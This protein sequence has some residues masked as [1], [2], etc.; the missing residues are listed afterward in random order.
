VAYREF[1]PRPE[2]SD[3]VACTWERR[4]PV[5]DGPG[6]TRVLPDGCIDLI[7][8]DGGLL[9][10]GPDRQAFMSPLRPG[11]TI[12]G[13]RLRPGAAGGVL[14]LPASE[15]RDTR[16]ELDAVWEKAGDELAERVDAADA[17]H[18][19]RRALEDALLE[20]L[21]TARQPDTLVLAAARLLGRPGSRVG[22]LRDALG[23]SERQLLRRFQAAVGYGPKTLDRVL[24]FQRFVS[25][26][27]HEDL[28]RAAADLGYADQA[29]MTRECVQLSG[30]TPARLASTL[31]PAPD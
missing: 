26:A 9:V 21:S 1:Q 30:L 8:R 16:V 25:M 29:H 5:D 13:I 18:F 19:R 11:E 28:A 27:P 3:L 12:V 17:P 23:V 2:L 14:G 24:R 31:P 4:V 7:W 15:L 10:A 22:A 20:R 6:A